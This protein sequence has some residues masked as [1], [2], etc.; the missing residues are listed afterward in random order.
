MRQR[1][2]RSMSAIKAVGI[3]A[4]AY[5]ATIATL[6]ALPVV[7]DFVGAEY[8]SYGWL[9]AFAVWICGMVIIPVGL[10]F[11]KLLEG[12]QEEITPASIMLS[13]ATVIIG[14]LLALKGGYMLPVMAAIIPDAT[15]KTVFYVGALALWTSCVVVHPAMMIVKAKT[16]GV[17]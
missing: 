11:E 8:A 17:S 7:Q 6:Y 10:V 14:I 1:E 16:G 4:S 5:I 2:D 15:A 12:D 13:V 3:F 9:M